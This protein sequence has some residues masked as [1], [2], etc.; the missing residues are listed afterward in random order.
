MIFHSSIP[1]KYVKSMISE[2]D[3]GKSNYLRYVPIFGIYCNSLTPHYVRGYTYLATPWHKVTSKNPFFL[4]FI[5][6][7]YYKTIHIANISY[8]KLAMTNDKVSGFAGVFEDNVFFSHEF[9]VA[10]GVTW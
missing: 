6:D 10:F 7:L 8:S 9:Y 5:F 2:P 1:P 4:V 3:S